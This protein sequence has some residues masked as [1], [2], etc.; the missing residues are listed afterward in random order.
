MIDWSRVHALKDEVGEEDF[1]E[2]ITLFLEEVEEVIARLWSAPEMAALEQD[3]HFLKSSALTMGFTHFADL[4]Q[5]GETLA[6]RERAD[7]IDL[8]EVLNSFDESKSFFLAEL[9]ERRAA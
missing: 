2:V 5:A 9:P 1:D 3:L 6:A 8:T 7:D 4:C